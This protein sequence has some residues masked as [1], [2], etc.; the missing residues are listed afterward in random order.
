MQFELVV[1]PIDDSST[2]EAGVVTGAWREMEPALSAIVPGGAS[3]WTPSLDKC[4]ETG[5]TYAWS[6]RAIQRD[7]PSA[8][9]A[10]LFFRVP[11]GPSKAEI[12]V[13]LDLLRQL[14]SAPPESIA[15]E[16]ESAG[17]R[18]PNA[19]A[20]PELPV[21][22]QRTIQPGIIQPSGPATYTGGGPASLR[23]AGEV[24]S[25]D[26][27]GEPRLWGKGRPGAKMYGPDDFT[28]Q[29]CSHGSIQFGL[30][31]GVAGWD[32]ADS[33]CPEGTWV[34]RLSEIQGAPPC[35]TARPDDGGDYYLC[36]G[37]PPEDLGEGLHIGWLADYYPP[38]NE[39]GAALA[40]NDIVYAYVPCL[41]FPAWCCRD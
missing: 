10:P 30:S 24:R 6:L 29:F 25:V 22:G 39:V 4:L 34:C 28:G 23:V 37:G 33:V 20:L 36:E 8:W 7:G 18:Q 5:A 35:N 2:D 12:A 32:S 1:Y 19:D 38:N 31:A 21:A 15:I 13:A 41:S 17:E 3:S 40:E 16:P 27:A 14:Q 26:A 9:A 11:E